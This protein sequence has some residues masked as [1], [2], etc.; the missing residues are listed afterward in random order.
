MALILIVEDELP[1]Q[2]ILSEVVSGFGHATIMA[3]TAADAVAAV[4]IDRPDAILLDI[5]LPDAA[6]TT[7]LQRLRELRLTFRSLC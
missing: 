2:E 7:T 5:V 3:G 1:L 6:G 4:Q